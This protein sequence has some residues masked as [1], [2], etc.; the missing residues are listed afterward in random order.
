ME[1]AG[2]GQNCQVDMRGDVAG[3]RGAKRFDDIEDHLAAG[4]NALIE[5]IDAAVHPIARVMVDVDDEM[6]VEPG[7]ACT[8]KVTALENNYEIEITFR[9]IGD[10]DVANPWKHEQLRGRRI[11]IDD[12]HMLPERL[13]GQ[14]QG[15]LRPD[16]IAVGPDVRTEQE[17]LTLEEFAAYGL[18]NARLLLT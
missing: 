11:M 17:T 14:R 9:T 15:K 13:Q 2:V 5:P 4:G 16:R 6:A 7:D 18:Q 8:A 12:A 3:Q 10:L 1:A